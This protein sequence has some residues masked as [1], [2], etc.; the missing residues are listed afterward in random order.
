MA[1]RMSFL[2]VFTRWSM[3]STPNP[4]PHAHDQKVLVLQWRSWARGDW[5]TG[6][7][8]VEPAEL[9]SFARTLRSL[10]EQTS[11]AGTYVDHWLG[12]SATT[13]GVFA[14]VVRAVVETRDRLA[15]NYVHLGRLAE[16]SARELA[17][18]AEM[19]RATDRSTATSLE[20]TVPGGR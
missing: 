7:V 19:Y 14:E 2:P 13:G 9:E 10:A 8:Q 5:M 12:L 17:S 20:R 16:G 11:T 18:A 3:A 1:S 15:A 4:A 6:A